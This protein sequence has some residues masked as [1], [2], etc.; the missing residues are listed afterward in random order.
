MSDYAMRYEYL[1]R[2]AFDCGRFEVSGANADIFRGLESNFV[3]LRDN[4]GVNSPE[5]KMQKYAF[6]CGEVATYIKVAVEK[7]AKKF[8]N[9][10]TEEQKQE[11]QD[12]INLLFDATI[13]EIEQAIDK[14]ETLMLEKGVYPG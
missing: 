7:F 2:R 11:V 5:E 12:I 10:L 14:G 1:I 6:S 4:K 3:H 13:N 9:E 8:N